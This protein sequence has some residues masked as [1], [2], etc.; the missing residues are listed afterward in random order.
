M[1]DRQAEYQRLKARCLEEGLCFRCRQPKGESKNKLLCD[2]CSTV[3]KSDRKTLRKRRAKLGLCDCGKPAKQGFKECE[4]CQETGRKEAEQQ[5]NKHLNAG[6]CITCGA[7]TEDNKKSCKK[8][9]NRATKSIM[10]RYEGNKKLGL[11]PMCGGKLKNNEKF[12]CG[13]CQEQHRKN[14]KNQ[15]DRLRKEIINHYGN[16]C[17]CCGE[18]KI[19][20]LHL[21][22]INNDGAKHR[23]ITGRHIY[24]WTKRNNFPSYLR[25]LCANC[26]LCI[27][28]FKVCAHQAEPALPESQSAKKSQRCGESKWPFLEFDHVNNDGATKRRELGP[29]TA[30]WLI[31]NG[32]PKDIQILCSNCNFAKS[33]HRS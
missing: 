1:Y 25:I 9:S 13:S 31:R 11:C 23:K 7:V 24:E 10:E 27:S 14:N 6:T 22:H 19:E 26:N 17:E 4:K 12:R 28:K 2:G 8:C 33:N 30:R 3:R 20:S 29:A 18:T 15:R 5:R 16:K 32:F 21:D